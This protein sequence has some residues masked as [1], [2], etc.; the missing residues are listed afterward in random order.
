MV[1]RWL[2]HS[3]ISTTAIYTAACGPEEVA[4]MQRFWRIPIWI[5]GLMRSLTLDRMIGTNIRRLR[6]SPNRI[7][8][9]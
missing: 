6:L 2:G 7:K 3:R 5:G 8:Y 9:G 1:Q 4:F